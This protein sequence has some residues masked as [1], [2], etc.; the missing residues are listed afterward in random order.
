[1]GLFSSEEVVTVSATS[2]N[3]V[4][5]IPNTVGASTITAI[6]T[7]NSI[8]DTI[9][10]DAATGLSSEVDKA[11]KYGLNSYALGL[12]S[13]TISSTLLAPETVVKACIESEINKTISIIFSFYGE[14]TPK[15][16][17]LNYLRNIR[18]YKWS[19][20]QITIH[21]WLTDNPG[22]LLYLDTAVYSPNTKTIALTYKSPV[23]SVIH[24]TIWYDY[25]YETV[26]PDPSLF[27]GQTY[28]TAAY[29]ILNTKTNT[30]TGEY[31]WYYLISTNI[32]QELS[33]EKT[34]FGQTAYLPVVPIRRANTD[35][36][37]DNHNTT[38]LY[39]TSKK[40]LDIFSIDIDT[41]AD[42]I[43]EN[44]NIA[45]IDNAYII[46]G[47]D[48]QTTNEVNIRYLCE[49]FDYLSDVSV[50][51]KTDYDTAIV[52]NKRPFANVTDIKTSVES[53]EEYGLNIQLRYYYITSELI[54]GSI[55]ST[56]TAI[57][58]TVI[59][60]SFTLQDISLSTNDVSYI[61]FQLQISEQVYKEV[62]VFGLTHI[63]TIYEGYA[64]TTSLA[65]SQDDDNNNFIIPLYYGIAKQ[66][67][68]MV[69]NKLYYDCFRI[70]ITSY[71]VQTVAWYQS[72]IFKV[73]LVAVA[74]VISVYTGG[75]GSWL[76][77]LAAAADIGMIALISY[78][79]P[80]ILTY[81]AVTYGTKLLAKATGAEWAMVIGAIVTVI[82]V[83]YQPSSMN[84]AGFELP[85]AQTLLQVGSSLIKAGEQLVASAIT[86]IEKEIA[87]LTAS[88]KEEWT[89][90]EEAEKALDS[91]I[92][93][94]PMRMLSY[95]QSFVNIT[96]ESP[97]YFYNRT[98]H[99]GNIGAL[100][101]DVI[102][103]YVDVALTLPDPKYS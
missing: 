49:Y 72:G 75:A 3:L 22:R 79:L 100:S 78:I 59:T 68:L 74:I 57:S 43:N 62:K 15:L 33:P 63:N 30:L 10:N 14:L 98:I 85:T 28:C 54:S 12:P 13:G 6:M 46:F 94:N 86:E 17:I 37:D 4:S 48:I 24:K 23:T 80:A 97:D 52:T 73:I 96:T 25:L 102:K 101:L 83:C 39:T 95:Q 44:P 55:G 11:Y 32:Y 89:V 87:E 51:K 103:Y 7:N 9:L 18:G 61:Q 82:T 26:T 60:P 71:D 16:A 35:L 41:I 38:D 8:S 34:G 64:V 92:D 58:K 1:M 93:L 76:A 88:E 65:D 66:L 19:D 31:Y 77:G 56:G 99:T 5:K 69:R 50:Y 53:L 81:L 70:I 42:K 27:I 21:P 29:S 47:I 40:L 90:L 2:F 36:T 67:P 91:G 45:D 84:I 20:E